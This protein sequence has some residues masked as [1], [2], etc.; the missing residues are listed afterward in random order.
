MSFSPNFAGAAVAHTQQIVGEWGMEGDTEW[1]FS[2]SFYDLEIDIECLRDF[3]I[4][5]YRSF[6]E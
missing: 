5:T 3:I 6:I 1:Q 4:S 2:H